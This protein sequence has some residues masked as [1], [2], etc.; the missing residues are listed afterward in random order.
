MS[1]PVEIGLTIAALVLPPAQLMTDDSCGG[2]R[3]QGEVAIRCSDYV[4]N[5]DNF[6]LAITARP[7]S[8]IRY[9]SRWVPSCFDARRTD[10]LGAVCVN[11]LSCPD[12]AMIL[13]S[14]FSRQLT[15]ASGNE[16][17][18]DW[19]Y[20]RSECRSLS[21]SGPARRQLT[22]NDVL[23]AVRR[24]GIPP[25]EVHAPHYTLV[26]LDTTFYTEPQPVDK[27]L[28]IIGY[29]V[30]VHIEPASYTWH[31][32]DGSTQT[33]TDPGHPYPAKD[34]THTYVHATGPAESLA[35]SVDV[36]YSARYAVD[37]GDWADIPDNITITGPR[38]PLP[39]KQASAVLVPTD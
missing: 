19:V 28:Q 35:V 7:S 22:W 6:Y 14:L 34:I 11:A 3:A 30:D 24:V 20:V 29:S 31:W 15:D 21:A 4:P 8:L 25:G 26:N 32:G 17:N 9:D 23:S 38:T 18:R 37:G 36:T 5:A 39:I 16:I 2:H 12:Q 33:T 1:I 27:T 10:E 13:E